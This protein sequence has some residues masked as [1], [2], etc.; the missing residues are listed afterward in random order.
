MG[1]VRFPAF[2]LI[3]IRVI[4]QTLR[5]TVR[6]FNPICGW[7]G[8]VIL[9]VIVFMVPEI[10]HASA[11]LA[12]LASLWSAFG[13][14]A[15]WSFEQV[16]Q[17]LA[18][19]IL[20]LTGALLWI[21]GEFLDFVTDQ[22]VVNMADFIDD[23][24]AI[25]ASWVILRDV[26]NMAFI[27]VLLYAAIATILN[28]PNF[29]VKGVMVRVVIF[30]LLLNF[31]FFFGSVVIDASNILALE[32][33]NAIQIS[34]GGTISEAFT[35]KLG[36]T[37]VVYNGGQTISAFQMAVE[38][39]WVLMV[40]GAVFFVITAFVFFT[41]AFL[42]LWRFIMLLALLVVSPIAFVA[43]ILPQTSKYL[44][45]WWSR[46]LHHA[47]LAPL[48]FAFFYLSARVIYDP[49]FSGTLTS[50][51]SCTL[52][53]A[54]ANPSE[55]INSLVSF[56]IIISLMI[57]S[58]IAAT[59]IGDKGANTIVNY[60]HAA[61]RKS[62][63]YLVDRPGQ[64]LASAAKGG[65]ARVSESLQKSD[66]GFAK[67][68]RALP[69]GTALLAKGGAAG[70]K[71]VKE[72]QKK[73]SDYSDAAVR[74]LAASSMG[75]VN[76]RDRA[77]AMQELAQRG[78]LAPDEEAGF[79]RNKIYQAIQTIKKQGGDIGKFVDNFA[80]YAPED[81]LPTAIKGGEVDIGDMTV[82]VKPIKVSAVEELDKSVFEKMENEDALG[83]ALADA[84][85]QTF[86]NGHVK[87]LMERGDDAARK[88]FGKLQKRINTTHNK[89]TAASVTHQELYEWLQ[90]EASNSRLAAWTKS[91]EAKNYLR[92]I[93]GFEI[94]DDN[95]GGG[96]A[97][98]GGGG[99]DSSGGG[100]SGGGAPII[101]PDSGD[102]RN[103]SGRT[104]G[105]MNT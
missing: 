36:I 4:V 7:S 99:N 56:A 11:S 18:A 15:S 59:A 70:R 34:E 93:G 62:R 85:S 71:E 52:A 35:Q 87:K 55:C 38:N 47:F 46:L 27:F 21:A 88:F 48:L 10:A 13:N 51:G 102:Q 30:A 45:Q 65:V 89:D 90:T 3:V 16:F 44:K 12:S 79:T 76:R 72:T 14:L 19:G 67:T 1:K 74:N 97:N 104:I 40:M 82:T 39:S 58:L 6:G 37:S 60:A 96:S 33:R 69:G 81:D 53:N 84:M 73:Y 25:R 9:T 83:D 2:H 91:P 32:F 86:H 28:I 57:L 29:N 54:F 63:E 78:K 26:A 61:R 68:I 80:Q 66:K 95:S 92:S 100:N 43:G 42:L 31:S 17:G 50:S 5:T 98:T 22:L 23:V 94:P 41:A 75:V 103:T 105:R 64:R 49:A 20:S 8:F 77:A 24:T 101:N